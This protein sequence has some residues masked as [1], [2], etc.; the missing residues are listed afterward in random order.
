MFT[1]RI[2]AD[3]S[4]FK[5]WG[6][7]RE[8]YLRGKQLYRMKSGTGMASSLLERWARARLSSQDKMENYWS[9]NS[10]RKYTIIIIITGLEHCASQKFYD[11]GDSQENT[12]KLLR[13]RYG[14]IYFIVMNNSH[15]NVIWLL[16]EHMF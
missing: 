13:R 10:R 11:S 6:S 16:K 2:G 3:F 8:L 9:S 15:V 12:V 5:E 1:K 14:I 7:V 4:S